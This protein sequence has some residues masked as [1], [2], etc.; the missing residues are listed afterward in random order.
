MTDPVLSSFTGRNPPNPVLAVTSGSPELEFD[1]FNLLVLEVFLSVLLVMSGIDL[2]LRKFV[3]ILF[4]ISVLEAE[5]AGDKLKQGT[6]VALTPEFDDLVCPL[7][8][9]LISQLP[10]V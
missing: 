2:L 4:L 5:V 9:F 10:P 1:P 3:S 6:G 8:N 7:I